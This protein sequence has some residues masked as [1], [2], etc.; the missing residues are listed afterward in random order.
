L[1]VG[2]QFAVCVVRIE[3]GVQ[4]AVTEVTV[5]GT[6]TVTVAVPDLVVS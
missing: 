2:V 3:P 4:A 1:T 5:L 6:V